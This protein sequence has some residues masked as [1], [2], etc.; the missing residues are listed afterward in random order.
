[1]CACYYTESWCMCM[2][3][4]KQYRWSRYSKRTP[5]CWR[6]LRR[7]TA[8]SVRAGTTSSLQ[9]GTNIHSV[10]RFISSLKLLPWATWSEFRLQSLKWSISRLLYYCVKFHAFIAKMHDFVHSS[11]EYLVAYM[12][13]TWVYFR[14]TPRSCGVA[15]IDVLSGVF[16]QIVHGRRDVGLVSKPFHACRPDDTRRDATLRMSRHGHGGVPAVEWTNPCDSCR[17]GME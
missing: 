16:C 4:R 17:S 14:T 6:W 15:I 5:S 11:C 10:S 1:M 8:G 13:L 3:R 7:R 9:A 12:T 2:L